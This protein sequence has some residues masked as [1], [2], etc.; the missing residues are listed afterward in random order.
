MIADTGKIFLATWQGY[1][2]AFPSSQRIAHPEMGIAFAG[3]GVPLFNLAF[4]KH[5]GTLAGGE[6]ESLIGEFGKVLTPYGVPGLLLVRNGQVE[7]GVEMQ[8][9]FHMPGMVAGELLPPKRE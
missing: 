7:K 6:L 9:M 4:S 5:S 2:A 8:A 3:I 1:A